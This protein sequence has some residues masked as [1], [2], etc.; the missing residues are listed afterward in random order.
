V[1]RDRDMIGADAFGHL[2]LTSIQ[3]GV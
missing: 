2:R 1:R 3:A